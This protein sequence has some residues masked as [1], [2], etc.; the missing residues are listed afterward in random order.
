MSTCYELRLHGLH[1]VCPCQHLSDLA[2]PRR[3]A[4]PRR[5]DIFEFKH[6]F[7]RPRV[8]FADELSMA[9]QC[10]DLYNCLSKEREQIELDKVCRA[11]EG[12][13]KVIT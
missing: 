10:A 3:Q 4:M 2:H 7:R 6:S 5:I 8:D 9:R 13:E 1:L 11:S 12:T